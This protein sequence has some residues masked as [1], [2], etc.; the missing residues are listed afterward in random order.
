MGVEGNMF[1]AFT[2]ASF[3][4]DLG[5]TPENAFRYMSSTK[6]RMSTLGHGCGSNQHMI[7]KKGDLV[8]V[9]YGTFVTA[10]ALNVEP[11]QRL[12]MCLEFAI[13]VCTNG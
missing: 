1:L 11:R 7:L 8:W 5:V 3:F 10:C 9:P 2:S 4:V 13:F 12:C 6:V